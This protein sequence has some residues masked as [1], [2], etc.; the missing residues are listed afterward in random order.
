MLPLERTAN[1]ENVLVGKPNQ[2]KKS[3][4]SS[5]CLRSG[6]SAVVAPCNQPVSQPGAHCSPMFSGSRSQGGRGLGVDLMT[7]QR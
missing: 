4:T 1:F 6:D 7:E 3:F 2:I 5:G